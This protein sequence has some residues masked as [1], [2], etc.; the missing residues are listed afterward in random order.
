MFSITVRMISSNASP[1]INWGTLM[2]GMLMEHLRGAW[3]STLHEGERRAMNQWIEPVNDREFIWH[4]HFLDDHLA[5]CFMES[6]RKNDEWFCQHNGS[7][8]TFLDLDVQECS[9]LEYTRKFMAVRSPGRFVTIPFRTPTTHKSQGKYVLFPSVDL[10][11]NNIRKR[12][13]AIDEAIEPSPELLADLAEQTEIRAYNLHT[14]VF[15]LEGSWIRGYTGMLTLSMKGDEN[16]IRFGQMFF[17][18]GE[19]FGL[20]I[21]TTLGMG[22]CQVS[23]SKIE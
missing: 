8:M 4:L 20:G 6:C 13:G 9:L 15:G 1:S 14:A 18:L 16:L 3:P 10:I 21:K 17:G 23:A 2:H 5:L 19:W 11:L 12:I 22:G 7:R